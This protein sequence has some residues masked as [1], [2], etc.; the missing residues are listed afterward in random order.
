MGSDFEQRL[1]RVEVEVGELRADVTEIKSVLRRAA[2][3]EDLE[4]LKQFFADRDRINSDRQ[5]WVVKALVILFG[6]LVATT[7]GLDKA[8]GWWPS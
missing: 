2:T 3:K 5:W 4:S 1:T 6:A 8:I 7:L